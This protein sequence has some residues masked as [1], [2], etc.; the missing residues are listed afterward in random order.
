M[1]SAGRPLGTPPNLLLMVSRGSSS[2]H[3]IP[4]P[5]IK[6]MIDPGIRRF[7]RRSVK[8]TTSAPSAIADAAIDTVGALAIRTFMRP[9]KSPGILSI[10]NPK[11]SRICVLAI[12]HSDSVRE[13]DDDRT[14][15]VFDGGSEPG[16]AQ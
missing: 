13:A 16:D 15:N 9:T 6:A 5:T 4:V 1:C 11:K 12:K 3:A 7:A 10:R 2:A 8:M 14:G